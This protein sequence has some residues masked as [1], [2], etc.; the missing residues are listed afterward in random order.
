MAEQ[1]QLPAEVG[2]KG[3]TPQE[4]GKS[5]S[6]LKIGLAILFILIVLAV[7]AFLTLSVDPSLPAEPGTRYPY[8]TTYAVQIPDGQQVMI[9]GTPI[10]VLSTGDEL[11]LKIGD[12]NEKFVAGQTRTISE[13]KAVFR[14]L[15]AEILSTNYKIDATYIG[16][17]GNHAEFYLIVSTSDQVPS[18]LIEQILPGEIKAH[19]A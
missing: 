11:I 3:G 1:V 9:A 14:I 13:R 6:V 12:T 18:S 17:L 19:P 8:T 4:T 16:R 7:I 10:I 15:G 2:P 5:R